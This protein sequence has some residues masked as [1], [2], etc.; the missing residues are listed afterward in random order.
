VEW[1]V[2]ILILLHHQYSY[3]READLLVQARTGEMLVQPMLQ[4]V[5]LNIRPMLVEAVVVQTL[6]PV[7]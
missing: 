6:Y 5:V 2:E 4:E 7:L 1:L 3:T